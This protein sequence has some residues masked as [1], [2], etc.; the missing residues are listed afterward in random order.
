MWAWNL[1]AFF[2]ACPSQLSVAE[3]DRAFPPCHC[4]PLSDTGVWASI[5]LSFWKRLFRRAVWLVL[6]WI[7]LQEQGDH[8]VFSEILPVGRPLPIP[9]M[10]SQIGGGET[11][12]KVAPLE[13]RCQVPE[14]LALDGLKI[15][16]PL[17]QLLQQ[18]DR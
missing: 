9:L 6:S 11:V 1:Q 8:Q 7:R 4:Q 10:G 5:A 2:V 14:Q 15:V 18:G 16:V 17:R 3:S 12:A 13:P